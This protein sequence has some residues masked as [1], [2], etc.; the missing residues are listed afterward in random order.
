MP[1]G[2]RIDGFKAAVEMLQKLDLAAQ[3]QL[4]ADIARRDP[5]MAVRLK[6]SLTTFDDLQYLTAGMMRR[7]LQDTSI[8]DWGLALRGATPTL[9]QHV[10][11]LVS[12]N[13]RSD[14]EHYLKGPPR[15]LNDVMDAQKRLMEVV[16]KL[17]EKGEL[18]LSKEKSDNYV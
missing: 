14:M 5:E 7:L 4:L 16:M 12:S 2:K 9:S 17:K 8:D 10:L 18:V 15:S 1:A 6:G 13:N 3:Q 11:S